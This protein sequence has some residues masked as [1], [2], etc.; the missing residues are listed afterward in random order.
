[1]SARHIDALVPVGLEEMVVIEN[2]QLRQIKKEMVKNLD[3]LEQGVQEAKTLVRQTQSK[4]DE[5]A[6][7]INKIEEPQKER[8]GD[9]SEND[10][11]WKL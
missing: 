6:S 11:D 9:Q 10:T 7:S 1:M 4:V 5:L 8:P 3:G 2:I